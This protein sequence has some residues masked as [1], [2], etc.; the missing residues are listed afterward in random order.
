MVL[1]CTILRGKVK[2]N[3]ENLDFE[4]QERTSEESSFNRKLFLVHKY[5]NKQYFSS[6]NF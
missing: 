6:A 5:I 4:G 1:S 3:V 2:E